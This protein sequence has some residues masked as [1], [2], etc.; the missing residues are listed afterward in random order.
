M[1]VI[2]NKN[3][4]LIV[5]LVNV[6]ILLFIVYVHVVVFLCFAITFSCLLRVL[7]YIFI[8]LFNYVLNLV[9]VNTL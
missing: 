1:C 4:F 5:Y 2:N 7:F 3:K 9:L 6:C 8:C